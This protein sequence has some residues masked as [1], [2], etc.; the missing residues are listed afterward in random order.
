MKATWNCRCLGS[1]APPVLVLALLFAA[2]CS[3]EGGSGAKAGSR[4]DAP[5]SSVPDSVPLPDAG[6]DPRDAG[7]NKKDLP[8]EGDPGSKPEDPGTSAEDPGRDSAADPGG[9]DTGE[10]T[11]SGGSGTD[12]GSDAGRDE[13]GAA[14]PG[15]EEPMPCIACHGSEENPAPPLDL[16]G[17][18]DVSSPGVGAH[19]AHLVESGWRRGVLCSDCHPVPAEAND[20]AVATH[21]DGELDLVWSVV[22]GDAAYDKAA[23]SCAGSWCHGADLG[24]DPEGVETLRVPTWNATDGVGGACG[25][26]CHALPPAG[27]HPTSTDCER[28]HGQVISS[29]D[30]AAPGASSWAAHER[31]V[32]GTVDA[33]GVLTCTSC[34]GDSS[35]GS[36][37]PPPGTNGATEASEPGVGAHTAHLEGGSWHREVQCTDCHT[38]PASMAHSDG[39]TGLAWGGPSAAGGASPSYDSGAATCSGVACHGAALTAPDAGIE[40]VWT[41]SDGSDAACGTACHALPPGGAHPVAAD[42]E[43]CHG[44]VISSF[45]SGEPEASTWAA[46]ERHVDGVVDTD[47]ALTCTSCHGDPSSGSP[48]P[49]LSVEGASDSAEPGVG[50]HAA[51]LKGGAW[52]RPVRCTDCHAVPT[53]QTHSDGVTGLAWGGP[54]AAGGSQPGYDTN[55]ATCSG[56]ACHGASLDAPGAGTE[57]VWTRQG[58]VDSA[59]G[60]ACHALPPGGSHPAE[61]RCEMCHGEVITSSG[62]AG[63]V[64]WQ[65][66]ARHV[67]GV[68]DAAPY[69]D[70]GGWKAPTGGSEHHGTAYFLGNDRRDE[71][72]EACTRCHGDDLAGGR[73]GVSCSSCHSSWKSCDFCHGGSGDPAPPAGV[74][75]ETSTSTLAVG[76][77][78]AH[79]QA[80]STHPAYSC[81]TCH[82][83]PGTGDIDHA[84][85]YV[86]SPSLA[87]PGHHGDVVFSGLA[88]G[89][90]FDVDAASG[91][92]VSAR[93]SCTGACHSNG[94]GGAPQVTPYWAGGSWSSGGCGSCHPSSPNSRDHRDHAEEGVGCS[95]CHS[96]PGQSGHIDGEVELPNN[97]GALSIDRDD[98][99][100]GRPRCSGT[101]HGENHNSWCW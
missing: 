72:D 45:D 33:A 62:G 23:R 94:R 78:A 39:V 44:A 81:E 27:S 70:L 84:L 66:P 83:V 59:C 5:G 71:H 37:A 69:H 90:T 2:A 17:G 42:C 29:F 43:R 38:M 56:V 15:P 14:D 46:A 7:G 4:I 36:A 54:S 3:G 100:P 61:Q 22:A 13:G 47:S 34:H 65:E 64:A 77:H 6:L 67:D 8:G 89:M 99:G 60:A 82:V 73:V 92:P 21:L 55:G 87:T 96:S 75:G 41:R 85:G 48:A 79:L 91:D 101:C 16:G 74:A 25:L 53:S 76:R 30:S 98:C 93:G 9:R 57:P 26:A 24:A 19:Q 86:P 20:P 28:C 50:A 97:V 18:V 58:S 80:S 32:D 31:H 52:H 40:P 11:D 35:S 12:E 88:E 10:A 51:H 63:V 1:P 95:F 49:P 68:V